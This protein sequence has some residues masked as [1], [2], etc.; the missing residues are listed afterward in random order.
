MKIVLQRPIKVGEKGEV[1]E[2][3]LRERLCAGDYRGLKLG[4]LMATT[5]AEVPVD[6]YLK[7]AARLS[8]QPD[9]VI[10]DLSELDLAAVINA[11]NDFRSAG[12]KT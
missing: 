7:L 11:I 12:Q 1:T 5:L 8:G 3:H 6:D 10:N 9:L 2:L 4:S